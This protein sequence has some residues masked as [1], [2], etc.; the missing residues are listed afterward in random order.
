M[1]LVARPNT[2]KTRFFPSVHQLLQG[3]SGVGAKIL[4]LGEDPFHFFP[5]RRP[6]H[7]LLGALW[8]HRQGMKAELESR[9]KRAEFFWSESR[10]R[11]AFLARQGL[12]GILAD[13]L[14]TMFPELSLDAVEVHCRL[15]EEVFLDTHVAFFN[16]Y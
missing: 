1:K 12:T 15:I 3:D 16:G 13:L 11:M 10:N 9:W 6:L 2:G 5:S 4:A 14:K 7:R 8:C